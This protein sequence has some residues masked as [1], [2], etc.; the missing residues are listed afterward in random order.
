[1]LAQQILNKGEFSCVVV[2][3]GELKHA[4]SGHGVKPLLK[5]YQENIEDLK[6]SSIADKLIG[7]AAAVIL[8]CA[9][10]KEVYAKTI[11]KQALE[12]LQRYNIKVEYDILKE[13]IRNRDDTDMCP[14]EKV[15]QN[16]D[17]P[18][19]ALRALLNFMS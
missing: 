3:E 12:L 4:V 16:V 5:L 17:E 10:V 1:M 2:Q 11:S 14:L 6:D 7:K 8:V 9:S 15:V 19:D 18:D 13:E